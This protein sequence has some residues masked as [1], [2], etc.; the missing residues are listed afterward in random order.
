MEIEGGN[1]SVT[2]SVFGN[3][4]ETIFEGSTGNVLRSTIRQN[5]QPV[6]ET[7]FEYGEA[8]GVSYISRQVNTRYDYFDNR[9][10]TTRSIVS[11]SNFTAERY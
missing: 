9:A 2:E 8:N 5:G 3:Q 6:M 10:V 11:I 4:L 1:F 7:T